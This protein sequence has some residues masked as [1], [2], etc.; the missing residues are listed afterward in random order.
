[1]KPIGGYFELELSAGQEYYTDLIRLNTGRNGLEY[2]LS[3][4]KYKK[5]Y[6]P[7]YTCDAVLEPLEKLN[8]DYAFY[9]I[10]RQLD[11]VIDF[12]IKADEALI[13]TNY[14]GLKRTTVKRMAREK[15]HLIVDNAQA[16]FDRPLPGIDT[17]YSPRKFFGVPD[18]GYVSIKEMPDME[19]EEDDSSGRFGHLLKR[20][21]DGAE[22]GHGAFLENEQKL[23]GQS[24]KK[25]SRLTRKLL[26]SIDY[27]AVA[28]RR[29]KNFEIL[30][31]KLARFNKLKTELSADAAPMVY[32]LY[33]EKAGLREYLIQ[34]KIFVA[35]YWPNVFNWTK[36]GQWE[37]QLAANL[38]P[39]PVDQRYGEE[40]MQQIIQLIE[41]YG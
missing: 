9:H 34:N 6:L 1:M 7:Y 10:D 21:T 15:F 14:F 11:P 32:P 4:K 8:I 23:N 36:P 20:I 28:N 5:V 24:V 30:H 19:L 13:Y 17:F 2:I 31:A 16:F 25:M 29:R 12:E 33:I 22:A 3:V 35:T 37:H 27:N 40:E 41:K 18:G 26:A 38:I 39:L